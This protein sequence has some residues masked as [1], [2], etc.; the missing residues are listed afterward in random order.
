MS[1]VRAGSFKANPVIGQARC[2]QAVS[3][4]DESVRKGV[5]RESPD[6]DCN[7]SRNV[8]INTLPP[9]NVDT[10]SN[11]GP[12]RTSTTL[13]SAASLGKLA[14]RTHPATWGCL[15]LGSLSVTRTAATVDIGSPRIPMWSDEE[16]NEY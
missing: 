3:T 2:R 11:R 4:V 15:A 5:R 1:I 16:R 8:S 12:V 14:A 13:G 9:I 7:F 10:T 6:Q